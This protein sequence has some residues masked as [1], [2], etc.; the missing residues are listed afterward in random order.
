MTLC[1]ADGAAGPFA[2][3]QRKETKGFRKIYRKKAGES[4]P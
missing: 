2:E 1:E 3:Q 4:T